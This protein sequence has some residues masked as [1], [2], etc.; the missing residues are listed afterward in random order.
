[1]PSQKKEIQPNQTW[2]AFKKRH[3]G[4]S[5]LSED[6]IYS[7]AEDV[8]D[9]I[10]EGL[11]KFFTKDELDFER[12]LARRTGGGFFLRRPIGSPISVLYKPGLTVGEFID[13]YEFCPP[14]KEINQ[15]KCLNPAVKPEWYKDTARK[16]ASRGIEDF[17]SALWA[18]DGRK[19]RDIQAAVSQAHDEE[20]LIWRRAEAYAGWLILNKQFQQELGTLRA[21]CQTWVTRQGGFPRS[22]ETGSGAIFKRRNRQE[23][24][25]LACLAFYKRWCLD[26]MLTWDLPAPLDVG[27]HYGA[28]DGP[29]L[30]GDEG[31]TLHLPWYL[32]R[33]G[34]F[35]LQEVVRR[36]CF[37]ATPE[38]LRP[39]VS[40]QQCGDKKS[41]GEISNQRIYGLYRC[42][43]LVLFRRYPGACTK[44]VEKLDIT[45]ATLMELDADWV[46][47]LRQRLRKALSGR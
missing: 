40:N 26:R 33:G 45:L 37:E 12:D 31:V 1:M 11:P 21:E 46:K 16:Q 27:L 30:T 18:A 35:D 2:V 6:P 39:W 23:P 13:E 20:C 36:I 19:E 38:H 3:A 14:P 10:A 24:G 17:M 43:E 22:N 29:L 8:L 34:K 4:N 25:K 5:F 9:A 44:N 41:P 42:Y 32:L 15:A 28:S 7:L 47:R